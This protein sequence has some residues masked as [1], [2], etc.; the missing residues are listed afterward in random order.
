[1]ETTIP[2]YTLISL[3]NLASLFQCKGEYDRAL[4]LFEECLEKLKRL[5]G[6][7]HNETLRLLNNLASLFDKKGEYDRAL[8]L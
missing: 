8:P 4:P 7:D 3:N 6:D 5:F 2:I 1:M